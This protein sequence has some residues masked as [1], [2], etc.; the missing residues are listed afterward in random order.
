MCFYQNFACRLH[1]Y[2][3]IPY[4]YVRLNWPNKWQ[5][6]RPDVVMKFPHVNLVQWY[7]KSVFVHATTR[8]TPCWCKKHFTF[9]SHC[10]HR[11]SENQTIE[12]FQ[13]LASGVTG[14]ARQNWDRRTII[15]LQ[16]RY[17]V[18]GTILDLP[19]AQNNGGWTRSANDVNTQTATLPDIENYGD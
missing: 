15:N 5:L 10:L 9:I 7:I 19:K 12:S 17:N 18:T 3:S 16:Q 2:W 6:F 1:R 4:N 8:Y 11:L 13:I 14:V